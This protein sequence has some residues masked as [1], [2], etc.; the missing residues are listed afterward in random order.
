MFSS[1]R[2][3]IGGLNNS[4]S[5]RSASGSAVIRARP[6]AVSAFG[7]ARA[8][9]E[10]HGHGGV[11]AAMSDINQPIAAAEGNRAARV[12]RQLLH[13]RAGDPP[14]ARVGKRRIAERRRQLKFLQPGKVRQIAE[15]GQRVGKPGDGRL[16]KLGARR[17]LLIAKHPVGR[18]KRPQHL[19]SASK[20]DD[21][22][23]VLA[24][25]LPVVLGASGAD[26]AALVS[27]ID[28]RMT[29]HCLALTTNAP[30][31]S[32]GVKLQNRVSR[33]G[34]SVNRDGRNMASE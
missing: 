16:R 33:C 24:A 32:V 6:I 30:V 13:K 19:E 22:I 1:K 15:P 14:N 26:R 3:A 10:V 27:R 8:E 4:T 18:L 31:S 23:A 17:D 29:V 34:I 12:V 2:E 11:A 7:D 9:V 28:A 20:G 5:W 21:E 25:V